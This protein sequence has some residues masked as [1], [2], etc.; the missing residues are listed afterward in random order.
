MRAEAAS[1]M[2]LAIKSCELRIAKEESH[3]STLAPDSIKHA[4]QQR[5]IADVKEMVADMRQRLLDLKNPAVSLSG[6]TGPAGAPGV[7]DDPVRGILGEML[8]ESKA[9]QKKRIQEATEGANDLS[10]LVKRKK[11]KVEDGEKNVVVGNGKRKVDEVE[12]NGGDAG[13]KKVKFEE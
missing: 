2:E 7:D 13:G 12:A 10:R 1:E 8:G 6:P 3:L 4:E 9:E 11:V 5:S